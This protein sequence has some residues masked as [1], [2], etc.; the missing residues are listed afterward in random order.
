MSNQNAPIAYFLT[1]TTY[2]TRL[3]GDDRGTV[4]K[5]A[6]TPYTDTLEQQ[7]KLHAHIQK[8]LHDDPLLLNYI[9]RQTVLES[10][11]NT[12]AHYA[13][14]LYAVHIRTN[15][16]HVIVKASCLPER[17]LIQLK[18]FASRRLKMQNNYQRRK[19]FWT[20]HGSTRFL[21]SSLSLWAAMNYVID[22]QGEKMACYFDRRYDAFRLGL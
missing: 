8:Q 16:V 19:T 22:Q 4:H 2:G 1:F 7:P 14:K 20:R 11:I 21:N 12:C 15:H 3:H 5:K 13:W 18:A 9:D 17:V 10:I 6:N